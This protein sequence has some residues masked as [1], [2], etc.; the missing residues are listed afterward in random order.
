MMPSVLSGLVSAFVL[1]LNMSGYFV[2]YLHLIGII[3]DSIIAT[4][5]VEA[6]MMLHAFSILPALW[7]ASGNQ[8]EGG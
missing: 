6:S 7:S 4:Y 1:L 3:A 5:A 2:Y 8:S